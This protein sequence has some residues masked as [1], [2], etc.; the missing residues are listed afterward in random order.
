MPPDFWALE[1]SKRKLL[2]DKVSAVHMKVVDDMPK[3]PLKKELQKLIAKFADDQVTTLKF[4]VERILNVNL[5]WE[6]PW[7]FPWTQVPNSSK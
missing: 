3:E 4:K 6:H 5:E 7:G 1:P 2:L